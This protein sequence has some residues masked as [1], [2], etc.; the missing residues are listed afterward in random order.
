[1]TPSSPSAR[2]SEAV[3]ATSNPGKLGEIREILRHLPLAIRPL[4]DFPGVILPEEGASYEE[5]AIPKPKPQPLTFQKHP[6]SLK[7]QNSPSQNT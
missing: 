5:N 1:M 3:L 7:N 6:L 4:S 2:S